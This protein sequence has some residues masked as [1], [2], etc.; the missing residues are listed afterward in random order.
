LLKTHTSAPALFQHILDFGCGVGRLALAWSQHAKQVTGVD[1]SE[2]MIAYGQKLTQSVGNVKLLVNQRDDLTCFASAQFDL[3][4]SHICL[5]HMPFSL[6]QRYLAEFSRICQPHGWIAFQLPARYLR[7][8]WAS[9]WRKRLVDA[10]P[11]QWGAAYRRWRHGST[12]TFDMFFT[13][14]DQVLAT[15][16]AVGLNL[17][18]QEPDYSAGPDTEGWIYLFQK[19]PN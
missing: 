5:Q 1:I 9:R 16:R 18:H 19:T 15:A 6:A 11:F 12:A 14:A 3:V 17:A 8:T 7:S 4:F 13:S 2:P 10:L